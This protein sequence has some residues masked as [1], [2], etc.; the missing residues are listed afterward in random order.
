MAT[1]QIV[2]ICESCLQCRLLLPAKKEQSIKMC[3]VVVRV[4]SNT[5]L[6][7]YLST[8]CVSIFLFA[9]NILLLSPTLTLFDT[10]ERELEE[11]DNYACS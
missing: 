6:G 1:W 8:S 3:A 11:L 9:D 2:Y 4:P 7:C 10:R 5:H